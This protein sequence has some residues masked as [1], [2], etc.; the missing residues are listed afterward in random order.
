MSIRIVAFYRFVTIE[1]PDMLRG[2]L[3][4][5][6][7]R[8]ALKGVMLIS[9]EG[10]NATMAG[11]HE[12]VERLLAW[13]DA[14]LRF[15][16]LTIKEAYA[17]DNPFY[18]LRVRLKK[19]IVSLGVEGID[20]NRSV[21]RYVAPSDWNQLIQD[22]TVTLVDVRN[23]YEIQAGTFEGALNPQTEQFRDFPSWVDA[24]LDPQQNPK[25]AMFCTGGIRCEKATSYLKSKGF[26]TVYHLEGGI[27]QYFQDVAESE[28]LWEGEC[29]VFDQRIAVNHQLAPGQTQLCHACSY[30]ISEAD[31]ESD[32]F[33]LGVSCPRCH[34]RWTDEQKARFAERQHQIDLASERTEAHLGM[35]QKLPD[36][37]PLKNVRDPRNRL[38]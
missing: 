35:K 30:P 13:L 7:H 9:T 28:S 2:E 12:N 6:C 16:A 14:D 4:E 8:L 1:T 3:R 20:P 27:L 24:H 21:G 37:H 15:K 19:E 25:V 11:A 10:I 22:P 33:V 31:R 23:D 26:E 29:F 38:G 5:L 32:L 18:R 36:A 17:E 34:D